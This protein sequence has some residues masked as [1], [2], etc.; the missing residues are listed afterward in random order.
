MLK[1]GVKK[2]QRFKTKPIKEGTLVTVEVNE[3][4]TVVSLR[5]AG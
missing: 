3:D 2:T 1:T 4:G 5:K